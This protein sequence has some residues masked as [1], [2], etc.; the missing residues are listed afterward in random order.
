M[1]LFLLVYMANIIIDR[2]IS[3]CLVTRTPTPFTT[4]HPSARILESFPLSARSNLSHRCNTTIVATLS[5][6]SDKQDVGLYPTRGPNLD[7]TCVPLCRLIAVE[8]PDP[9]SAP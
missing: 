4:I 9:T 6:K 7:K 3:I 8:F 5:I 2:D 1:T